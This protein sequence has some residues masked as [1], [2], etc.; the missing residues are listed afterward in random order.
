MIVE[1][2]VTDQLP[3]LVECGKLDVAGEEE[4]DLVAYCRVGLVDLV[5]VQ[6]LPSGV[7][8]AVM[9]KTEAEGI[10]VSLY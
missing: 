4:G 10:V 5:G 2:T 7:F 8:R 6:L 9:V 3:I 1:S